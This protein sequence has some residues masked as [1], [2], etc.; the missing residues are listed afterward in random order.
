MSVM[1]DRLDEFTVGNQPCSMCPKLEH[2]C[3]MG[4]QKVFCRAHAMS[5]LSWTPVGRG[6]TSVSLVLCRDCLPLT[7]S[8]LDKAHARLQLFAE[9]EL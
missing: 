4:C 8:M 7:I 3:C 6:A 2:S 9:Y 5:A 1:N